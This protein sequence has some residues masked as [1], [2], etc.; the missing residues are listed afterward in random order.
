[1]CT[2]ARILL[3]GFIL[4]NTKF[5]KNRAS[6]KISTP[7][8]LHRTEFR[9]YACECLMYAIFC[10]VYVEFPDSIRTTNQEEKNALCQ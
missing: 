3:L 8:L 5:F 2:N 1:M 4:V 10:A 7:Q 9:L 6:G